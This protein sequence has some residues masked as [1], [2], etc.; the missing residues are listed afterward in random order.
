M[1]LKQDLFK[2]VTNDDKAHPSFLEIIKS[3]AHVGCKSYMNEVFNRMSDADGNFI[4]QFQTT[5]YDSRTFELALFALF[6]NLGFKIDRTKISPDFMLSQNGYEVAVEAVT[7]SPQ[8]E[9]KYKNRL[10]DLTELSQQEIEFKTKHEFPLKIGSPLY[11]KLKKCYWEAEH[12]KGKPFILAIQLFH[13]AG[14][15]TYSDIGV[16][17]YLYG[18][19]SRFQHDEKGNLFAEIQDVEEHKGINKTIPAN[20]FGLPNSEYVSAVLF[21]NQLTVSKFTRMGCFNGHPIPSNVTFQRSGLCVDLEDCSPMPVF[22]E[23]N[24]GSEEEIPET[25]PQG[26]TLILNPNAKYP[27]PQD[28]FYPISTVSKNEEGLSREYYDFHPHTSF[29]HLYI[30]R[31]K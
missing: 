18:V 13:E 20:F 23:Y 22:Y 7:S 1:N 11:T 30:D 27:L 21:T 28:L 4:Q 3:A 26:T 17:D 10:T 12:C 8:S 2:L 29:T 24:K 9:H 19:E 5:G 6:E 25:W 16:A 15:L 14:S 31:N